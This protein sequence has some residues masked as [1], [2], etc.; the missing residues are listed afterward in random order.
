MAQLLPYTF[1][2]NSCKENAAGR[3]GPHG[4]IS[5]DDAR[6]YVRG[7]A[8]L[9][10]SEEMETGA[11]AVTS[12]GAASSSEPTVH[13]RA[14]PGLEIYTVGS[15]ASKVTGGQGHTLKAKNLNKVS[16][17][18]PG[19]EITAVGSESPDVTGDK[20]YALKQEVSEKVTSAAEQWLSSE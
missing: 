3:C 1:P 5:R 14:P 17:P 8:A 6:R 19:C 20:D 9:S 16:V 11:T 12:S 10:D 2:S 7:E 4:N 13:F 18:P 15:E